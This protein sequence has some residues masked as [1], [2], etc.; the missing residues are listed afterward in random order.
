M[1]NFLLECPIFHKT[2]SNEDLFYLF[3]VTL[4]T[5][6]TGTYAIIGKTCV[7]SETC[8]EK[9]QEKKLGRT[10]IVTKS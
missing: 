2:D 3:E 9:Y 7:K 6:T 1:S 8:Y 5:T 10:K 4:R